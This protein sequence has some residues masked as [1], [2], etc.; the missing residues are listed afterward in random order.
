MKTSNNLSKKRLGDLWF[1]AIFI[2]FP[3]VQFC[4]FYVGVNINSI[5]LAFKA[6]TSGESGL[7]DA[8][9]DFVWFDNFKRVFSELVQPGMMRYAW[10]NTLVLFLITVA[11]SPLALIVSYY[12]FQKCFGS[13][14]FRFLLYVPMVI[15]PLVFIVMFRYYVEDGVPMALQKWFNIMN[16]PRMFSEKKYNLFILYFYLV[17]FGLSPNVLMY[18]SAMSGID[19][20]ILEAARLD[21]AEGFT[22]FY[23]IVFKMIFSI[24][25]TFFVVSLSGIFTSDLNLFSFF[26]YDVEYELYNFGYYLFR[27]T[28]VATMFDYPYLSALGIVFSM[29]TIPLVFGTR[30]LLQKIGPSDE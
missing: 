24:F 21:G 3:I 4:I 13:G 11:A 16:F 19:D 10:K 5:A 25:S 15:S 2:A 1:Y 29:I 8:K 20:S 12:I 18:G 7:V 17:V 23:H 14:F 6:Y 26:S 28:A 30:K 9:Y 22:L 27:Q